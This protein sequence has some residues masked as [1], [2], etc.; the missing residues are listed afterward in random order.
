MLVLYILHLLLKKKQYFATI[1]WKLKKRDLKHLVTR[2][3]TLYKNV[4]YEMSHMP[5]HMKV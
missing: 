5:Y 1:G 4:V 2:D 3:L